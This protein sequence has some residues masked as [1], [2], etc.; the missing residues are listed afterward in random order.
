[1]TDCSC[2]IAIGAVP[3]LGRDECGPDCTL[4]ATGLDDAL[5]PALIGVIVGLA[6]AAPLWAALW[7][8]WRAVR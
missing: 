7:A 1:M 2:D 3:V 8:T 5:A 6:L 4:C